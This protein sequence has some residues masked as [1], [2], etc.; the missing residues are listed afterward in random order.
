ML[1]AP[2]S[3]TYGDPG[4]LLPRVLKSINDHK[5]FNQVEFAISSI[6]IS[7]IFR[8]QC[9][10][11]LKCSHMFVVYLLPI[12]LLDRR[13]IIIYVTTSLHSCTC[14]SCE[15]IKMKCGMRSTERISMLLI[16][17]TTYFLITIIFE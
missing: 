14:G 1:G 5:D 12:F 8:S 7:T 3:Q 13:V 15:I 10:S 9:I 4:S 16:K 11:G 6:D 2:G 17:Q